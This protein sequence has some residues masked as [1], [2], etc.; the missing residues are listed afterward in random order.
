MMRGA[1]LVLACL[2][3][4]HCGKEAAVDTDALANAADVVIT[5]SDLSTIGSLGQ[6]RDATTEATK[7]ICLKVNNTIAQGVSSLTANFQTAMDQETVASMLGFNAETKAHFGLFDGSAKASFARTTKETTYSV[8]MLWA[9]EYQAV[10]LA[11]DSFSATWNLPPTEPTF[12]AQCGDQVLSK[13]TKGGRLILQYKIDFSSLSDKQK[14]QANLAA[15]YG[16]AATVNAD[17]QKELETLKNRATVRVAAVQFGG[18]PTR[19]LAGLGGGTADQSGAQAIVNCGTGNLDG[20]KT[21]MTNAIAY[22]IGTG[23]DQFPQNVRANPQDMTYLYQDWSTYGGPAARPIP[24]AV[25]TARRLLKAK[26]GAQ[27]EMKQRLGVLASGSLFVTSSVLAALPEWRA[28]VDFNLD[29][30]QAARAK[31]YDNLDPLNAAQV[32]ACVTA[33][34]DANM[35]ALGFKGQPTLADLDAGPRIEYDAHVAGIGWQAPVME[36]ETAGTTGQ[37]RAMEA[38]HIWPRSSLKGGRVCY[39]VYVYSLGWQPEVCDGTLAGTTGR[40]LPLRAVKI[41]LVDAAPGTSICYAAHVQNAAWLPEVCD[42]AIAG[43]PSTFAPRLEAL[44]IRI[45]P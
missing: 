14:F 21:F 27:A 38:M 30:V 9:S 3:L 18:D 23:T 37:S 35:A 4:I 25:L 15:K 17:V 6:G 40:S 7:N 8:N 16:N 29:L 10:P 34:S 31:C 32:D 22:A 1:L 13:V 33:A 28:N 12:Y 43:W 39:S 44:Q 45:R 5:P 11:M 19:L 26:F 36:G 2:T 41:R 20:C 42:G 24:D